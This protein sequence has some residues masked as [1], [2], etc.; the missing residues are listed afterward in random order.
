MSE[1]S[2]GQ[3][4]NFY[5]LEP[6]EKSHVSYV[7]LVLSLDSFVRPLNPYSLIESAEKAEESKFWYGSFGKLRVYLVNDISHHLNYKPRI[8]TIE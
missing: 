6:I 7:Q 1:I 8:L 3:L 5:F 4:W 2:F